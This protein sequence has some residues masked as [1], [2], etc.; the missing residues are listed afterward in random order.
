M[1]SIGELV[2]GSGI[3]AHLDLIEGSEIYGPDIEELRVIARYGRLTCHQQ[4]LH[5]RVANSD[6]EILC[7]F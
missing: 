3:A 1:I 2:D 4:Q 6:S 5:Q 7:R